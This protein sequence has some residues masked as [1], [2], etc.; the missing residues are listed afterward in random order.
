MQISIADFLALRQSMPVIDVR[1]QGEFSEGHIRGALNVSL[2]TNEERVIVGTA[3]KQQGQQTAIKEGFRLVG[4]RLLD[5]IND[6]EKIAQGKEVLVNC[7]RGGMR[8]TNFCQFVSMAR[9]KSHSLKGGYKA[10]RQ[11]GLQTF[12]KP[13]QLILITGCTGSGKSELLRALAKAG[14][15]VLDLENLAN[16]KG[17]AFGGLMLPPQPSTEQFQNDL[18]EDLFTLDLSKRIWV[19]DESIT[20]GKISIPVDFWRQ[21]QTS[22][23]LQMNVTKEVRIQRL[24]TEYGISDKEEF[25][26]AMDKIAKRL[27]GQHLK[28]AKEKLQQGDMAATID[29]LLT[30]Y[31]KY[32]LGSIE[33]KKER[34]KLKIDWDGNNVFS[35]AREIK[36]TNY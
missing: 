22:P 30:Y 25:S 31:D 33:K 11:L 18:F 27:G 29:I 13:S 12:Q 35:L 3:Y 14:E 28:S 34:V 20:I 10:Y 19:E 4:P 5:I 8:S 32:Y 1:S 26:K 16:H 24:V 23:L 2:L 36:I 6:T 7:W 15:Q 9:I 21:M 17:S